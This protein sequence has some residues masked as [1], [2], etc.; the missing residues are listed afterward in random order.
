M[1]KHREEIRSRLTPE[2]LAA[3]EA[4]DSLELDRLLGLKPWETSPLDADDGE[5]PYGSGPA[6]DSWPQA[7][8]LRNA[9]LD[10]LKREGR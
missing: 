10:A 8:E 9:I 4:G 1:T 6:H 2:I 5:C 7:Q 3:F